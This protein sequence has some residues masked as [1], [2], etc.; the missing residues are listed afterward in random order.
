MKLRSFS[1]V[2]SHIC[3]VNLDDDAGKLRGKVARALRS[4]LDELGAHLP[5][6]IKSAYFTVSSALTIQ[7][8]EDISDVT[9]VGSVCSGAWTLMSRNDSIRRG[10]PETCS[11][12]TAANESCTACTFYN[13]PIGTSN[14]GEMYGIKANAL[15]RAEFRHNKSD[16]RL[17]FNSGVSEGDQVLVEYKCVG[18]DETLALI[19][20]EW[21]NM[22]GSYVAS[23]VNTQNR[24]GVAQSHK[25]NFLASWSALKTANNP[26]TGRELIAALMGESMPAPKN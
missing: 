25:Q 12:D 7:L 20:A 8:P 9:K 15:F 13:V 23:Q 3:S 18:S 21:V 24:P 14:Y 11:C 17:E 16:N 2:V 19:P 5:T 6:T 10:L 4:S 26:Y 1:S 22:L